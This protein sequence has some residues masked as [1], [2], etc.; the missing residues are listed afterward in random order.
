M[1]H[2][3]SATLLFS[4]VN[5]LQK[6]AQECKSYNNASYSIISLFEFDICQF[7]NSIV[8]THDVTFVELFRC[9]NVRRADRD[10]NKDNYPFL[11]FPEL[12]VM[13]N[14]FKA[15]Y[16]TQ[17]VFVCWNIYVLTESLYIWK[18]TMILV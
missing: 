11:N 6:E 10:L 4:T 15:F 16:E 2:K 3:E 14:G 18:V 8:F 1:E 13:H 5:F 9:R 12:Y 17:Q 7:F